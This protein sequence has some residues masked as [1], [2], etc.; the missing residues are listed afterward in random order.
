MRRSS[1]AR[2]PR[3]SHTSTASARSEATRRRPP[4]LFYTPLDKT[5]RF[6]TFGDFGQNALRGRGPRED[7]RVLIMIVQILFDGDDQ[8]RHAAKAAAADT[9]VGDFAEP[10]LHQV[11]PGTRSRDEVQMEP[12][13]SPEPRL[14]ARVLVGR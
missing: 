12:W 6:F 4:D 5:S 7:A 1:C 10:P 13:M 8:L 2:W 9:F 11:Q 3:A 14:H